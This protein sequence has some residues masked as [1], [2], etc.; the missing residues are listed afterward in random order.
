MMI[1]TSQMRGGHQRE[2]WNVNT[3]CVITKLLEILEIPVRNWKCEACRSSHNSLPSFDAWSEVV[4]T[5][6]LAL[7]GQF[8]VFT[9]TL[10]AEVAYTAEAL[11]ILTVQVAVQVRRDKPHTIT[12]DHSIKTHRESHFYIPNNTA[13]TVFFLNIE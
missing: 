3:C 9:F 11:A 12:T 13:T 5:T 4:L 1:R 10:W 2:A 8:T 7:D 6:S